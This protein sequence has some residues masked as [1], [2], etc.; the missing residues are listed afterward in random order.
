MDK[1]LVFTN[2][3]KWE[4]LQ[5]I[6][7]RVNWDMFPEEK[8]PVMECVVNPNNEVK[9]CAVTE[10]THAGI[11]LVYDSID[12]QQLKPLLDNCS[13]DNLYILI[14][15]HGRK[16]EE[17][18]P[19]QQHCMVKKGKHENFASDLYLPVFDIITDS[20]GEKTER[21]IKSIFMTYEEA[22]L[23]LLNECRCPNRNLDNSQAF[24]ALCQKAEVKKELEE[25]K[26]VYKS[27][28]CYSEYQM[29]LEQLRKLLVSHL[30]SNHSS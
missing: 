30:S 21:I 27:C 28:K 22:V 4:N 8:Q 26:K 24:L 23:E 3:E 17:F 16:T 20:E 18:G 5:D 2:E 7:E 1:V 12:M 14:H 10:L 25:F 6:P 13:N 9:L 19:W 15:T 29:D 11:Y